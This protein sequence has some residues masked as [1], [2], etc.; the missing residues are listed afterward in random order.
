VDELSLEQRDELVVYIATE[1]VAAGKELSAYAGAEL[2]RLLAHTA[3]D[4]PQFAHLL[5][6]RIAL[7]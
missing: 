6:G 5:G 4:H 3:S 2:L 1:L 7:S